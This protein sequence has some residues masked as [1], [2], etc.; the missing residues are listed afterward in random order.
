M[1]LGLR[2]DAV[3]IDQVIEQM[4]KWIQEDSR[5][6]YIVHASQHNFTEAQH[7][8]EFK[9]AIN[10]AD[11]SVPD[12]MSIVRLARAR[13]FNLKRRVYGPEL[14][15]LFCRKYG[16][17]F[18]HF[19]YGGL[20]GVAEKLSGILKGR[21]GIQVAGFYSPALHKKRFKEDE[22]IIKM[23]NDSG[24]DVLW[25]GLGVPKQEY[26]MYDHKDRLNVSV[27]LG[28]GAAF[29]YV[30]GV[31]KMPPRWIQEYGF[32]W[33]FRLLSEPRRLWHR[34]LVYG[35]KFYWYIILERLKLRKF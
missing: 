34:Y 8:E 16:H 4:I 12:G 32:E 2:V 17:K 19:F 14:M 3:Q 33:L 31:N 18:R 29:D 6:H 20:P 9:K 23:I 25:V 35:P 11:L 27:I 26:W 7:D 5:C 28:V 13:G 1:V 21:Y 15:E 24:A 22:S 10:S 30:S